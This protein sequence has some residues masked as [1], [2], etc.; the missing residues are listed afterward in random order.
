LEAVW[1]SYADEL[2]GPHI[3]EKTERPQFIKAQELIILLSGLAGISCG[4]KYSCTFLLC[5]LR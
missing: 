4:L 1:L 2:R 3:M 5:V